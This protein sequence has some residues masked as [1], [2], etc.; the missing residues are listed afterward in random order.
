MRTLT[1]KKTSPQEIKKAV[2]EARHA[3][4]ERMATVK[5]I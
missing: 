5:R 2:E 4:R 3:Q 1:E